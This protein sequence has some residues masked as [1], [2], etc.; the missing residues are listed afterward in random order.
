MTPEQKAFSRT[1]AGQIVAL[2]QAL[3]QLGEAFKHAMPP[4][5]AILKKG[6]T[7]DHRHK[8]DRG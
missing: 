8:P 3:S 2:Q 4:L 7:D 5:A 6:H 1:A